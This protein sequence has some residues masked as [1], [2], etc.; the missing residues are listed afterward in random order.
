MWS[1]GFPLNQKQILQNPESTN[2]SKLRVAGQA[3]KFEAELLL[4]TLN[5]LT[6]T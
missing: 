4:K 6:G 3:D 1:F 2:S 5:Q